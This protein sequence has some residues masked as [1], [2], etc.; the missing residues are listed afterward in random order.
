[1]KNLRYFCPISATKFFLKVKKIDIEQQFFLTKNY[2]ASF[3]MKIIKLLTQ[4]FGHENILRFGGI[5]HL[6]HA[7][8]SCQ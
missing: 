4:T 6:K 7:V 3:F 5:G 1:M 8:T 2:F